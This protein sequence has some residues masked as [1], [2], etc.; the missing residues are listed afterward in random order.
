MVVMDLN[1]LGLR[2][3]Q[4]PHVIYLQSHLS[5]R[6]V[7]QNRLPF[8]VQCIRQLTGQR[9]PVVFEK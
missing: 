1:V 4:L 8:S 9:R 5:L 6:Y 2:A 3:A 7:S